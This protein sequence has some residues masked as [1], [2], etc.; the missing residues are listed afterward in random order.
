M[1]E[2]SFPPD[3]RRLLI[4][5]WFPFL[6]LTFLAGL[7]IFQ[8]ITGGLNVLSAFALLGL[9]ISAIFL[10]AFLYRI[11]MLFRVHY[12]LLEKGVLAITFGSQKAVL[13]IDEITE[14]RSGAGISASIRAQAPGWVYSWQGAR[15]TA[16]IPSI[17][18][19]ATSTG[20]NSTADLHD[21]FRSR[22][23]PGRSGSIHP[24]PLR[25]GV[26]GHFREKPVGPYPSRP[27]SSG[28]PAQPTSS[29]HSGGRIFS[30]PIAR[31]FPHRPNDRPS[32][33]PIFQV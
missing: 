22:H 24:Q 11:V 33:K 12:G 8:L 10:P 19:L 9:G 1:A 4:G 17:E 15:Q 31:R 32:G 16:G 29:N 6:V 5:Q 27:S 7:S 25:F 18:W 3:R 23:F 21:R 30:D 28:Y 26:P 13:P 20:E 14:I 2:Q